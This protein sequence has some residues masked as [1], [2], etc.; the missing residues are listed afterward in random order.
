MVAAGKVDNR[1]IITKLKMQNVKPSMASDIWSNSDVSLMGTFLYYIDDEWEGLHAMLISCTGSTGAR[2]TGDDIRRQAVDDPATVGL[3]FE[4]VHAKG[5][6]QGNNIKKAW[7]GLPGGYCVGHTIE[8]A[9]KDY[10]QSEVISDVVQ[11]AKEMTTY[12]HRS[13][14]RLDRLVDLQK[15]LDMPHRKPPQTGNSVCW[16]YTHDSM[17]W[18][19]EQ[20]VVVQNYDINFFVEAH[21]EEGPY[22][23]SHMHYND[24][25]VN[26]HSVAVLFP[27]AAVV[28][29]IEVTEYVT[30]SLVLPSVYML[31]QKARKGDIVCQWD[32]SVIQ[33]HHTTPE[34]RAARENLQKPLEDLFLRSLP[35]HV[36]E[37]YSIATLLDPCFKSFRFLS[38]GQRDTAV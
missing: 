7:G 37:Q 19:R 24:R 21:H 23:D 9:V 12:F 31:I 5:S 17:N 22:A 34:V 36:L 25:M 14:H 15:Q 20:K 18:F 29:G 8:L 28:N 16:H 10:L 38:Q 3:T 4:D 33:P 11:K 1:R 6:D 13:S 32:D 27:S 35:D 2:H 26:K 30:A